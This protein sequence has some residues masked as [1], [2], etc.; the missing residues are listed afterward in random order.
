MT[1]LIMALLKITLLI[2]TKH[3]KLNTGDITYTA[4]NY[5]IN[6]CNITSMFLSTVISHL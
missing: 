3:I 5:Y 1:I 6:K 4:I 2:M